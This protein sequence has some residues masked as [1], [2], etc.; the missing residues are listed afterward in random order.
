MPQMI[1]PD[2]AVVMSA[3]QSSSGASSSHYSSGVTQTT[4]TFFLLFNPFLP[5][6]LPDISPAEEEAAT[7]KS[8]YP[9]QHLATMFGSTSAWGQNNQNQQQQQGGGLF[10][11]GGGGTFGQQN[12]GGAY[13]R[14]PHGCLVAKSC[15]QVL[16]VDETLAECCPYSRSM[17]ESSI[18]TRGVLQQLTDIVS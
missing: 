8:W 13:E 17:M 14:E 15:A 9:Q 12:T 18:R 7:R 2:N 4:A 6:L 11:G 3:V 16:I 1:M 10:G 5:Y